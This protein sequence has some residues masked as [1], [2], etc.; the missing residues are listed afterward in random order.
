MSD[1]VN[2]L[3]L[4]DSIQDIEY[5]KHLTQVNAE[6]A[7]NYSKGENTKVVLIDTGMNEHK[8]LTDSF[9]YGINMYNRT[10]D[11]TDEHGHGTAIAG[12]ISGKHT[13]VA[14]NTELY[15]IKVLNENGVGD[16]VKVSNGISF[17]VSIKADVLCMSLGVNHG[18]PV[19][20]QQLIVNARENGVT[21]VSAV[22]NSGTH[23]PQ[24][25]AFMNEVIG[26]G[27]I[28]DSLKISKFSNYGYQMDLLAPSVN[29]TTT[30]NDGKY[31]QMSGTSMSA[32]I[33]AGGIALMISYLKSVDKEHSP[34]AILKY[35]KDSY[36][37]EHKVDR[38]YGVFD[39]ERIFKNIIN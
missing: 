13:G 34:N 28:D 2:K 33:V 14:P 39:L 27:G 12:L 31:C 6:Y 23:P 25:P 8:D 9:K 10:S 5:N 29:V 20:V 26:V 35:I 22:G 36:N 32:P 37:N 1:K 30:F 18:L 16:M 3:K 21:V 19:S 17:A 15:V 11:I 38:G 24:F 4:L 7:W